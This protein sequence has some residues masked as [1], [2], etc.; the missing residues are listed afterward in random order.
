M[1]RAIRHFQFRL[2]HSLTT[3]VKPGETIPADMEDH[4]FVIENSEEISDDPAIKAE[5]L[6]DDLQ[7]DVINPAD[8][9]RFVAG[10]KK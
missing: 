5:L 7:A 4:W 3:P 8:V 2:S 9:P 1:R 6:P 10:R